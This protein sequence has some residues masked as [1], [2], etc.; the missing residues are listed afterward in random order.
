M[1]IQSQVEVTRLHCD[2]L[3]TL[4]DQLLSEFAMLESV[5][6]TPQTPAAAA[7]VTSQLQALTAHSAHLAAE[8]VRLQNFIQPFLSPCGK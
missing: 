8:A 5:L 6:A 1:D 3:R 7:S 2:H 4:I